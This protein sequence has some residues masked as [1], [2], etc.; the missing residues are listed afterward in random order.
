[1]SGGPFIPLR[2]GYG[3][4][5]V[6]N[7]PGGGDIHDTFRVDDQGDISGGHTTVR[8]PGGQEVHLPWGDE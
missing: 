4:Q 5:P 1:M 2:D 7:L 3:I 6:E 8:I